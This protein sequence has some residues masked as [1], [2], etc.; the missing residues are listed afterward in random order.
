MKKSIVLILLFSSLFGEIC[1]QNDEMDSLNRLLSHQVSRED[2]VNA[3][4][5]LTFLTREKDLQ[6]ALVW[7]QRAEDLAS[8]LK[9][10]LQMSRAKGN[11]GWVYFR[12][13]IWEKAFRYSKES[14]LIAL[15]KGYKTELGMAL[16]NLGSLYYRQDYYDEAIKNFKEAYKYGQDENDAYLIIR[17]L[18]N[19]A[20]NYTLKGE[21]DS[22]LLFANDAIIS[23]EKFGE[24]YFITF[25]HRV[26]GDIHLGRGDVGKAIE[27]YEHSLEI[28]NPQQIKTSQAS[29][30]HRLGNAYFIDGNTSKAL[31]Y[32]TQGLKISKENGFLDELVETY[33]TFTM[34]YDAKGNIP[35]AFQYQKAFTELN[36]EREAASNRERME[37]L[38]AKF[39]VEKSDAEINYLK[40]QNQLK[41]VEIK[42]FNKILTM[43]LVFTAVSVGLLFWMSIIFRKNKETTKRLV[44]KRSILEAQKKELQKKSAE[45][46]ESNRSKNRILSIL[47]HDLKSPVAQ[48]KGV[49]DLLHS[50]ELSKE[51]FDGISHI[52]KRN[53]DGLYENIDNILSWS[54]SQMEGFKVQ[55]LPTNIKKVIRPCLELLQYQANSKEISITINIIEEI[56]LV[57]QDLLQ[58]IIR[59]LLS[60]AIKFSNKGSNI[61]IYSQKDGDFIKLVIQDY[62]LGMSEIQLDTILNQQV[63]LLESSVGTDKE[64]GTGLGLNLCKEFLGLMG[65][66]LMLESKK[67]EGTTAILLLQSVTVNKAQQVI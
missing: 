41:E 53:V 33:K 11:L 7:G 52:L 17:S 3:L 47:G 8:E 14:Y 29:V 42:S 48:L 63:Y 62:G 25:T 67:G 58:L 39:E 49:L 9:D 66:A 56:A 10:S 16:N 45:L 27:S 31:E 44:E 55:L 60:N 57:D 36:A 23:N 40:V 13:G 54:K 19:L 26:L 21:L 50:Q 12:L 24:E 64:K 32:L 37:M 35:L 28:S 30:L 20:L 1:A 4:N 61:D 51:E 18:N 38:Q 34:I 46:T 2:R 5:K 22:A 6:Q 59:N 65:G 15:A 43:F